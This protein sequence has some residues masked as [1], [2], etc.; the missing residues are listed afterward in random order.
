MK[1]GR[2]VESKPE[3]FKIAPPQEQK[4]NKITQFQD[5]VTYFS[6]RRVQGQG[7]CFV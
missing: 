3:V 6:S 7:A 5:K 4:Q 1:S 2:A